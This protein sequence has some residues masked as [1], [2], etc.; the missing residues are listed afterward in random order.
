MTDLISRLPENLKTKFKMPGSV[1][2]DNMYSRGDINERVQLYEQ[3]AQACGL[4]Y[5]I[6]VKVQT[7]Q[8][9]TYAHTFFCVNNSAGM[10]EALDFIGFKDI[11]VLC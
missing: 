6:L 9:G 4:E 1:E 2:F 11:G 7:G 3:Q 8:K 5:P 10:H